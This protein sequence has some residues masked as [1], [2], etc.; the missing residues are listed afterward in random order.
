MRDNVHPIRQ[1]SEALQ[2]QAFAWAETFAQGL[3]RTAIQTLASAWM[4]VNGRVDPGAYMLP[5]LGGVDLSFSAGGGTQQSTIQLGTA[6]LVMSVSLRCFL[7]DAADDTSMLT[8]RLQLPNLQGYLI[9][10]PGQDLNVQLL[11][12]NATWLPLPVP[13]LIL[14]QDQATF[15]GTAGA[16]LAGN[17]TLSLGYLGS[18]VYG[19]A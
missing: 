11:A 19:L 17:A 5:A 1:D 18:W 16:A 2:R 6:L 9:G 13:W 15:T 4:R 3:P 12:E 7:D 8:A 14:P 10:A